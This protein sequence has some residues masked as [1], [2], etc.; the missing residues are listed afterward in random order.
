MHLL[1]SHPIA[2][3]SADH[4]YPRGIK[5]DNTHCPLFVQACLRQFGRPRLLD[6][7]CAGGGL[8]RDFLDA[9]FEAYGVDGS[10]FARVNGL[11]E[12]P[13]IE[14]HLFT[15]DIAKP[16]ELRED[17]Q[18]AIFNVI[19]AWE[20]LEHIPR[21]DLPILFQNIKTHLSRDGMF[22]ASIATFVDTV[23][24]TEYHI[25]LQNEAWWHTQFLKNGLFPL[26]LKSDRHSFKL[27]ELP[28]G[29]GN[30]L[31][32]GDWNAHDRPDMGF[33]VFAIVV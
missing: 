13:I 29:S 7:G 23:E 1:T 25:T 6:L 15:A 33:H 9:G 20:V 19:T 3:H 21:E 24:G 10:D 11:G 32:L 16:F 8:V 2:R 28:R 27:H 26:R 14:K 31:T 17:S 5:N 30:R 12:W 4:L 18:T 22:C